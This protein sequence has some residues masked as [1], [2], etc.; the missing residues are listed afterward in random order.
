MTKRQPQPASTP[1]V[2]VVGQTPPPTH[3]QAVM[4]ELLLKSQMQRVRLRH[5]RMTFSD[6]IEEVGRFR[7]A[8]LGRLLGL[9]L[10]IVYAR[11][12]YGATALYYPPAGPNRTPLYRDMVVLIATRWLFRRTVFHMQASGV[13]ELYPRLNAV[14]RWLFRRAY[15]RPDLVIRL[16]EATAP[17]DVCFHAK[18][19]AFIANATPDL[20]FRTDPQTPRCGP[21]RLL[22]VGNVCESKGAP[23]LIDAVA[24]LAQRGVA[25]ELRIVGAFMPAGLEGVLRSAIASAGLGD[26]VTLCGPK[27]GADKLD[28]LIRADVFCFPTHYESEAFPCVLVEAMSFGLPVVATRW[29]GVPSIVDE[30]QTGLLCP[31]HDPA[32]IAD[33]IERLAGSPELRSQMGA[34]GREKY[35]RCYTVDRYHRRMEEA[36][37]GV[38]EPAAPRG[39][40]A[41]GPVLAAGGDSNME[42]AR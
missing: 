27:Y 35:E 14:E 23:L 13:S 16:S 37:A 39:A 15:G 36:L 11:F 26:R 20:A 17:D 25:V 32:A 40:H 10:R 24:E 33:A 34:A 2:L 3:G 31:T 12:A 28:E 38:C 21:L 19:V 7:L 18:R 6:G 4:I 30:G 41:A 42:L 8:K 1:T 22:Y 9:V 5:V 29:R